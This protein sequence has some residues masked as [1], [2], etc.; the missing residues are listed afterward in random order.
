MSIKEIISDHSP[1]NSD[2]AV[3]YA[4]IQ[5]KDVKSK[6]KDNNYNNNGIRNI[7]NRTI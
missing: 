3:Y 1:I 6:N 2:S 4:L 5:M 7:Y